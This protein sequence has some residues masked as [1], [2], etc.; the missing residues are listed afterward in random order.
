MEY[1]DAW[2]ILVRGH[3]CMHDWAMLKREIYKMETKCL[4]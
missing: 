2:N 3:V 4:T 1:K